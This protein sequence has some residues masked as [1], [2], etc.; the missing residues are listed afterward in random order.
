MIESII[1]EYVILL[2]IFIPFLIALGSVLLHW[3]SLARNALEEGRIRI[4]SMGDDLLVGD[5][6]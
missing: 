3:L 2:L 6:C 4:D 1:P 5:E